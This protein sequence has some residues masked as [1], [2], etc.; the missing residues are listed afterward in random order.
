MYIPAADFLVSVA[1]DPVVISSEGNVTLLSV[2]Y[3]I[4]TP[5]NATARKGF[6][7]TE[8]KTNINTSMCKQAHIASFDRQEN[9]AIAKMTAQCAQ[10]SLYSS[11]ER[12]PVHSWGPGPCQQNPIKN[13]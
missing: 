12:W 4:A 8:T 13:V 3:D 7:E 11:K 2:Q 10:C 6:V 9:P 5:I 1:G